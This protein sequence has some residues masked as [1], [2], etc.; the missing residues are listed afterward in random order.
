MSKLVAI[1]SYRGGT[2]K[3]NISANVATAVAL[4]GKRVGI[5]DT[6]IP[7]PGIHF[8]FGLEQTEQTL[9]DYLW[10]RCP[11]EDTAYE[12]NLPA[13]TAQGGAMYL[14][15]A[16]VDAD[17][18]AKVLTE[19]YDFKKLNEA[20]RRF[21]EH[22]QLD[23]LFIDSHPGLNKETLLSITVSHLLLLILRPDRQDYQGTAV[24]VDIAKRLRV[25]NINLIINK[26]LPTMNL[27]ALRAKVEQTYKLSV[28]GL[29]PLSPDMMQLG[30]TGIFF[31]KYPDH[32]FT[33]EIA[34]IASQV[35]STLA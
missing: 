35:I 23:Y 34:N 3:S 1:H 18:I 19:G 25:K 28:A 17:D 6:D 11:I 21:S 14:I 27:A 26:A 32:E 30:S 5:I 12:I 13:V 7:S 24:T 2:G 8:I 22:H 4:Q 31:I 33:R 20:F 16:S 9:N 29:L 15:P 10:G